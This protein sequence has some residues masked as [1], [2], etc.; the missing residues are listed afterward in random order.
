MLRPETRAE[1]P[2]RIEHGFLQAGGLHAL[3]LSNVR[4]YQFHGFH[5]GFTLFS[6]DQ[7]R[8]VFVQMYQLPAGEKKLDEDLALQVNR[9]KWGRAPKEAVLQLAIF[10]DGW[11]HTVFCLSPKRVVHEYRGPDWAVFIRYA[12]Q[13][14]R[15]P[16][17][18]EF[19]EHLR[20]L[21]DMWH[22]ELVNHVLAV[23][24][25]THAAP[26][27]TVESLDLRA[28]QVAMRGMILDAVKQFASDQREPGGDVRDQPVTGIV[29]YF[30]V[31]NGCAVT[32][33]DVRRPF[34]VDGEYSHEGFAVLPR[35]NWREFVD[36]FY[37]G[38]A[39]TLTGLD[40]KTTQLEPGSG[41]NFEEAIGMMIVDLFKVMRTE[42][43]FAPLLL[44]PGAELIIE[45]HD[46][47]FTW[48]SEHEERGNDNR[49]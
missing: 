8:N 38:H 1:L 22:T 12:G 26:A 6:P 15:D 44:A 2:D 14:L 16:L 47:A 18:V 19:N 45:A 35:E 34:E 28:E 7:E 43:L 13:S 3:E 27:A 42:Q 5:T 32:S 46:A 21:P 37:D 23:P 17:F 48:P 41:F 31:G 10:P 33:F 40:G 9:K 4:C 24:A 11:A 39:V 36:R 30:D 29:V 49:I 25:E 20:Y